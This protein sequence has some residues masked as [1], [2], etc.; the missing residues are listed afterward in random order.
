MKG[1]LPRALV[2]AALLAVPG[3]AQAC[4][5]CGAAADRN[6]SIFLFTTILLS[7]LPLAL[8]GAGLLWLARH[9]RG[10]LGSEFTE[11]EEP[12]GGHPAGR[13]KP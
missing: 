1:P 4:A 10:R 13:G 11:R 9:A 7:L 6:R 2:V 8:V 12:L 3:I 5:A